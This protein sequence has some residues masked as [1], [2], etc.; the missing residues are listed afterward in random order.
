MSRLF[1]HTSS[2]VAGF[3]TFAT[4][5]FH[6]LLFDCTFCCLQLGLC[7]WPLESVSRWLISELSASFLLADYLPTPWSRFL[8]DGPG[9][10]LRLYAHSARSSCYSPLA[11]RRRLCLGL[12][13]TGPQFS[14][15]TP[16]P[17][18][19]C[20][21]CSVPSSLISLQ[22]VAFYSPFVFSPTLHSRGSLGIDGCAG[23]R[24]LA[25]DLT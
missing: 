1:L 2:S 21:T 7:G 16:L 14:L 19:S 9:L 22:F 4:A 20:P 11:A 10:F 23:I 3:G 18:W 6:S 17:G 13:R 8:K 5:F 12:S 15:G 24:R 25:A